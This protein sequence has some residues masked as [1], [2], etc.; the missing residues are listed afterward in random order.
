MEATRDMQMQDMRHG[1][2]EVFS[3][4][5]AQGSTYLSLRYLHVYDI[6]HAG[7]HVMG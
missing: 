1:G 7:D 2:L 4:G 3:I 5:G 6:G